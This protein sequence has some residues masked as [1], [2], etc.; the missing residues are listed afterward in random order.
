MA[1]LHHATRNK[2]LS[3]LA[4]GDT[5][6]E[7]EACNNIGCCM[8]RCDNYC[9]CRLDARRRGGAIRVGTRA[10]TR[11]TC[12]RPRTCPLRRRTT[13]STVPIAA[14]VPW[15]FRSWGTCTSP[16]SCRTRVTSSSCCDP[17]G[18]PP[19]RP[20]PLAGG[21]GSSAPYLSSL[22]A[23][24]APRRLHVLVDAS[25]GSMGHVG[26]RRESGPSHPPL[27]H[28]LPRPSRYLPQVTQATPRHRVRACRAAALPRYAPRCVLGT[29]RGWS[30]RPPP[31]AALGVRAAELR[32]CRPPS[33]AASEE[34]VRISLAGVTRAVRGVAQAA[35]GHCPQ[36]RQNRTANP[37]VA[38]LAE[39]SIPRC[40]DQ[41]LPP[42][43]AAS[44]TFRKSK[45]LPSF[46][47]GNY[48]TSTQAQRVGLTMKCHR[49][50]L[51]NFQTGVCR[52]VSASQRRG[53]R[54]EICLCIF[55]PWFKYQYYFERSTGKT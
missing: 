18:A 44:Q 14:A 16:S 43:L 10:R 22:R 47:L 35:A 9:T 2:A 26:V 55:E 17:A 7:R 53:A 23:L 36:A 49:V 31:T 30:Q 5:D 42:R 15:P 12:R 19:V 25:R 50:A 39:S 13:A 24:M 37:N 29:Y 33:A 34:P 28:T 51:K 46:F 1:Q 20:P 4:R 38:Y 27:P 21:T 11:D 41:S 40:C 54:K 3:P 8:E 6:V 52:H 32:R 45:I 48:H